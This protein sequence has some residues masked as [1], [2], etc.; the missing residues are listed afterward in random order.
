MPAKSWPPNA[1]DRLR[2]DGAVVKPSGPKLD[3]KSIWSEFVDSGHS[4]ETLDGL[5]FR[6]LCSTEE[7]AF[8]PEFVAALAA[9]TR[10]ATAKSNACTVWSCSYF[11]DWRAMADPVA[12]E[13]LLIAVFKSYAGVER[14]CYTVVSESVTVFGTSHYFS[15]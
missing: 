7:T 2:E 8:R 11:T 1:V 12:V 15:R 13:K 4:L 5:E 6:S 9:K 3:V 14:G 10:N